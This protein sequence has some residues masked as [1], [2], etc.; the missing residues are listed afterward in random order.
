MKH[1]AAFLS[2]VF[3]LIASVYG[4]GFIGIFSGVLEKP[5]MP[6]VLEGTDEYS[7]A[8]AQLIG[9]DVGPIIVF[10]I[11]ISLFAYFQSLYHRL[12]KRKKGIYDKDQ[13]KEPFVL[14][15]RSFVDDKVTRKPISVLTDSRSEEEI[16]V[17]V[18][19][20]IA[21]VYAI[22]D[23]KDAKMPNGAAR[24][25]VDD[26]H[27]KSTVADMAKR[28]TVVVLRLGKTDSFWW[29]VDMAANNIPLDKV[30]FVVPVSKTFNNVAT[31]YKVLLEHNIDIH[32]QD[33]SIDK[34]KRGSISSFLY[35]D[36]DG[37]P[38]TETV[39]TPRF[40]KF[41]ISYDNLLRKSLGGFRKK[42][43][44]GAPKRSVRKARLLL[45][46][47]LIAG[48]F[49]SGSML[50]N[51]FVKL[52]CQMPCEF[53][54]EC[55]KD[56][57][58]VNKYSAEI[59]GSNFAYGLMEAQKG[60]ITIDDD[61]VYK[62]IF[63]V[64]SQAVM[65]MSPDEF[66]Q[67]KERSWNSHLMMKKYLPDDYP[68]YARIMANAACVAVHYPNEVEG[69]IQQYQARADDLP[70]WFLEPAEEEVTDEYEYMRNFFHMVSEHMDDE[71][72]V[73]YLKISASRAFVESS[74]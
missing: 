51:D 56:S 45:V 33:I 19:S 69:L 74:Q 10:I 41:F 24:V 68:I 1:I 62:Y 60:L 49:M 59:N 27:W 55:V 37:T 35:F 2:V 21:P 6:I 7:A 72:I 50:F 67:L 66:E 73:D 30:L 17:D 61:D 23:P 5:G 28:A 47:L 71:N 43:G 25:Y 42:Y 16:L 52:K 64:E 31:L 14:Y 26:D 54:E 70:Q 53:V 39:Q 15:L 13:I 44:L 57:T 65:A 46:F 11:S 9:Q 38:H 32:A 36:K 8:T 4:I 20:D 22:G 48:F 12:N 63:A 18:M 3:G 34:K 58:F 29:E 40:T